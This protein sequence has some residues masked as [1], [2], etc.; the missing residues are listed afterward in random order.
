MQSWE[1][2]THY[3]PAQP[4]TEGSLLKGQQLHTGHFWETEDGKVA[5]AQARNLAEQGWE[6]VSVG[7]ETMATH[8]G[9]AGM[10]GIVT[11]YVLFFKRPRQM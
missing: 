6:L 2:R 1:L 5:Y 8:F 7:Q 3:I 9:A 10:G 4:M 11:G